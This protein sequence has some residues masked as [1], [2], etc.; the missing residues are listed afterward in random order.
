[1]PHPPCSQPRNRR[2]EAKP[3]QPYGQPPYGAAPQ[4]PYGY[5]AQPPYPAEPAQPK[6]GVAWVLSGCLLVLLL[7]I[8]GCV[9]CVSCAVM[10]DDR[11]AAYEYGGS[12]LFDDYGYSFPFDGFDGSSGGN[13]NGSE[14]HT[15]EAIKEAA[16][17][18][19]SEIADG[20]CSSGVYREGAGQDIEA[21]RYFFEGSMD[22]EGYFTVFASNGSSGGY[23]VKSFHVFRQLFA[24]LEEGD[25]VVFMGAGDDRMPR[26]TRPASTEAPYKSGLYH[27]GTDFRRAPTPSRCRTRRRPLPTGRCGLRRTASTSRR[28]HH[29]HEVRPER[30][31]PDGHGEGRRMAGAVRRRRHAG[32]IGARD[33]RRSTLEEIEAVFANDA[34]PP[35]GGLPRRVGRARARRMLDGAGRRAPQRMGNVM[36]DHLHANRLRAGDMLQHRRRAH[37]VGGLFHQLLPLHAGRGAHRHGRLRQAGPPSGFTPSRSRTTSASR[38]RR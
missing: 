7:G 18:L 33:A 28:Y 8:G 13:S 32:G 17:D 19:P 35:G 4:P 34:S 25:L 14:Y 3:Q 10:L 9:G 2:T 31:H 30:R 20:K 36:G 15:Y 24:D 12:Y 26:P 37:R 29:R 16:G 27:V 38:S 1:M 22:E 6:A 5:P 21:G 23:D 11:T